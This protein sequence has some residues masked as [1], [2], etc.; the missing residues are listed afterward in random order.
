MMNIIWPNNLLLCSNKT[1]AGAHFL[2]IKHRHLH[3]AQSY[4]KSLLNLQSSRDIN[5]TKINEIVC[6]IGVFLTLPSYPRCCLRNLFFCVFSSP[7]EDQ[8]LLTSK[9]VTQGEIRQE[10]FSQWSA[11]ATP[12][13]QIK[14]L[15]QPQSPFWLFCY[16][17]ALSLHYNTISR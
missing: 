11:I 10:Q 5:R 16:C 13:K 3:S 14:K 8:L 12:V 4:L 17:Y 1:S 6:F 15:E 9:W 7:L 2:C